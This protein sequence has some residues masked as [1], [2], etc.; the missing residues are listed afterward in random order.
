MTITY[1][2]IEHFIAIT[3]F[4]LTIIFLSLVAIIIQ[5]LQVEHGF[6][7]LPNSQQL[8]DILLML[9]PLFFLERLGYLICC[10]QKTW[11]SYLTLFAITLLPPLRLTAERCHEQKYIW[12]LDWQLVNQSLYERLEK[13]FLLPILLVSLIMVPFWITEIFLPQ[14][15]S[16]HPLL[17]HLINLGNAVIWVLFVTE[18]IIMIS[19]TKKRLDYLKKHWLEL[20]IILLPMFALAR[21]ILIARYANFLKQLRLFQ[22]I[23]LLKLTKFQRMLNIYRARSVLNRIIRI[24]LIMDIFRRFYQRRNPEQ[25]LIFLQN[26]LIETEQEVTKLR[27]QITET[28]L[29]LE[30][31]QSKLIE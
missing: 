29:L 12:L 28:E 22:K 7:Q 25:Y 19:I 9:W 2:S 3:M 11:N 5:Y 20:F 15:I 14:K 6:E 10:A 16:A 8:I 13:R 24:L 4:Y 31:K 1:Q 26:K 17:Y 21:F 18:F 23:R 30:T 27:Q